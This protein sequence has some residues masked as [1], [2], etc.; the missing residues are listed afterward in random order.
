MRCVFVQGSPLEAVF[1][2]Q[3]REIPVGGLAGRGSCFGFQL[4]QICGNKLWREV[5]DK[6]SQDFPRLVHRCV[7]GG[8]GRNPHE[9]EFRNRTKYQCFAF[10]PF[11]DTGI[12]NVVFPHECYQCRNIQEH[13]HGKF[14]IT[15]R[16]SSNV[17]GRS[18]V[19]ILRPL[20]RTMRASGSL[21]VT[22]TIRVITNCSPDIAST[23]QRSPFFATRP[24]AARPLS[25][26]RISKL[27]VMG[28]FSHRNEEA[29]SPRDSGR[30]VTNLGSHG[31][32]PSRVGFNP[33]LDSAGEIF[34]MGLRK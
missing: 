30:G 9:T 32:S 1:R 6:L 23:F 28:G 8:A 13:S 15:R 2:C 22:A 25:P 14:S 26:I 3:L 12:V 29:S 16:V 20:R 34:I 21:D 11:F 5:P 18:L 19:S 31:G 24:K 17:T 27:S 4:L 10:C 33:P 7:V